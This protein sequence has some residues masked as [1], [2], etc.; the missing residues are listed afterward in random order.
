MDKR[1]Y[2]GPTFRAV[3]ASISISVFS[4]SSGSEPKWLDDGPRAG[5]RDGDVGEQRYGTACLCCHSQEFSVAG[6]VAREGSPIAL[7]VVTDALGSSVE[8]VPNSFGNFFGHLKLSPPLSAVV[9]GA[10]GSRVA[11]SSNAPSGDC[12]GC[13]G[14]GQQQPVLH[15]P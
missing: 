15:G 3:L 14:S 9:Y 13:H 2:P 1:Q 8:T 7:V 12:N 6:S 11:M 4:C 10:D 5:C